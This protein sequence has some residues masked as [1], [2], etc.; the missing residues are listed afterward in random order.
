MP[1]SGHG[2]GIGLW[3][4]QTYIESLKGNIT[5]DSEIGKGSQFTV[6]LPIN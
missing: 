2:M 6:T 5:F 1:S 3:L 4:A